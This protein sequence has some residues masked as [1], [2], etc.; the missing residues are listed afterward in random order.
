MPVEDAAPTIEAL[1]VDVQRLILESLDAPSLARYTECVSQTLAHLLGPSVVGT[2][3]EQ[4]VLAD[5]VTLPM[6]D[7]VGEVCA[8]AVEDEENVN[9]AFVKPKPLPTASDAKACKSHYVRTHAVATKKCARCGQLGRSVGKAHH[10]PVAPGQRHLC[11]FFLAPRPAA[12]N[13]S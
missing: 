11:D 9:P 5:E 1:P 2:F 13:V 10:A 12:V 7:A 8:A 4:L 6:K 3:W